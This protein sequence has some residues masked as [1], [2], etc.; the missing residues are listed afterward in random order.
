MELMVRQVSQCV[1]PHTLQ[2]LSA[3]KAGKPAKDAAKSVQSGG[4]AAAY[5][6]AAGSRVAV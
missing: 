4:W 6:H 5:Q 3:L 1:L 2:A